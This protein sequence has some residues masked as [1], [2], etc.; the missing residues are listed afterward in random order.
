MKTK[1]CKP[2]AMACVAMLLAACASGPKYAEVKSGIPG[3]KPSQGRIYFYRNVSMLIGSGIQPSVQLNG[4]KLGDAKPGGFFFVDQDPGPME[5][6]LSTEVD[7]RAT[8]ALEAGQ[9]RYIHMYV[10]MG[11]LIYR[12]YPELVDEAVALK[13]MEGLNY[14]GDQATAAGSPLKPLF[15]PFG[16]D[17]TAPDPKT[18]PQDDFFQYVNGGWLDRTPI[19]PD[20]DRVSAG[21]ELMNRVEARLHQLLE[22][23]AASAPEQ[24]VTAEQKV[25]AMYAAF[26]DSRRIEQLG[27]API[28]AQLQSVRE[29]SDRAA[30][31][32]LMGQSVHDFGGS[33]FGASFDL[34][35]KDTE[36]YA[37]Y[38]NQAGLGM[39]D[40]DY[41]LEPGFA[42][43][44]AAYRAYVQRLLAL[45]DWPAPEA[46][47]DGIVD[48]ETRIAQVS[49]TKAEQRD[50]PK[51]YNPMSPAELAAFAP[52]FP[53]KDFLAGAR[54][55][56]RNRVIVGEKSAFP[57]I[58]DLFAR[59]PI[60]VLKAW[61]AFN[62]TDTA[63]GYLSEPFQQAR[64]EFRDRTLSGQPEMQPRWKRGVAAVSGGDC[65]AEPGVCFGTL[66]WA[67][68]QLYVAHDFPPQTKAKVQ[69]LVAELIAA[70]HRRIERL[71]WMGPATKKEALKKL[72]T[73]TVKVGY[74][75]RPRDYSRV[76]IRRDDL[77]GDVRRAAD[78][79]WDFYVRRSDGPVDMADWQM[80]PQTVDAYNGSLRD[81][82]F[83]AA[84]LQP[85]SFDP[86]A[87]NAV[88]YGDIGSIIG[89]ELTHGFDDQGRA[90]DA[91]GAL[92]DWWTAEDDAAF[93]AR[94]AVLGAQFARFEPVPGMHV[95]PDLTMGENIADL[96]GLLIS[97]DAYHAS[98]KGKPA[99]VLGGLTGDQR[100][101]M[102]F[103]QGW[104][105]KLREDAIRKQTAS[106]P[107]SYRKFRVLG[108]VSNVD[109][110]YAAFGVKSGDRMYRAPD[111]RAR[112]W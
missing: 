1:A 95:N 107:H 85:P 24:A 12:V 45:V 79:D 19:P 97:L 7:R 25:G 71:D 28:R 15:E 69:Q 30:L 74:P 20:Q 60:D 104:R 43:Q 72:D 48:L 23:A 106:D 75:D 86:V 4:K 40:R 55:A 87:D 109:D 101:F 112:I 52:G 16:I 105:G 66:N 29:A 44:K 38:L 99:P 61:A 64:F 103:A 78:A 41:Y 27:S 76:V 63:A 108:P 32:H 14:T 6:T 94:A 70:F 17:L 77:V 96:G 3:L 90:I 50:L 13:D 34:D 10:G 8:F 80:T 110:W 100:L 81:I 92:R 111:E 18:R 73:Y 91:T 65:G 22:A 56:S 9:V 47:A 2:L 26:M 67:V 33:I 62:I 31:A 102:A 68:G 59:A 57:K 82:V 49:W 5:V 98:L 84:I 36:H 11:V 21:K 58:A 37:L 39:P 93:K 42:A 35:L 89:H 46:A 83:P 51:L 53:W 54:L 88:N